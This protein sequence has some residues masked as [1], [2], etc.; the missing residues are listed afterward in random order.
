MKA[1]TSIISSTQNYNVPQAICWIKIM[2]YLSL[3]KDYLFKT[4]L[5]EE[6]KQEQEKWNSFVAPINNYSFYSFVI[7]K[8]QSNSYDNNRAHRPLFS[9][10]ELSQQQKLGS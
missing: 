10:F 2:N 6:T 9:D 3:F 7:C 1:K 4:Y 5:T 8:Q